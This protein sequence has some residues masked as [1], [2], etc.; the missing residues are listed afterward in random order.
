MPV[1]SVSGDTEIYNE[2]M[3]GS[4]DSNGAMEWYDKN[5][6]DN[7][8]QWGWMLCAQFSHY[9]I[10]I[11]VFWRQCLLQVLATCREPRYEV[12]LA[13]PW[14]LHQRS[15]GQAVSFVRSLTIW[16]QTLEPERADMSKYEEKMI[17]S[18]T[19]STSPGDLNSRLISSPISG[20]SSQAYRAGAV[21]RP[22][23]RSALL[24]FPSAP[25]ADS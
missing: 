23:L 15:L 1:G 25:V 4:D 22:S 5:R 16:K 21:V 14:S 8:Q 17:Q 19:S 20:N 7:G 6:M 3:I 10:Q 12:A 2:W 9:R 13:R 11:I 18:F 24:G